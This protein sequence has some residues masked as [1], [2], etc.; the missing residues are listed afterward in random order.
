[1]MKKIQILFRYIRYAFGLL[2]LNI[3]T[4]LVFEVLYKMTMGII[5]KP[6]LSG[7]LRLALKIQGLSF[8]SD[9][10]IGTFLSAPVSWIFLLLI[11]VLVALFT[12]FDISCIILC[13]HASYRK[14]KIPLIALVVKG[15][16]SAGRLIRWKNWL[17]ILYLL[18]IIPVTHAVLLS[19]YITKFT[20]PDFIMEYI[21]GHKLLA[22]VYVGFWIYIGLRSFHWIY[23]LHYYT[24]ENCNFKVARKKSWMLG[25]DHYWK[26]IL[27]ILLINGSLTAIYYGVIFLGAY[28]VSAVNQVL[29]SK[30]L[31]S[32]L[33]LSGISL[34]LDVSGALYY[35]FC[36]PIVFLGIS[37]MFYYY[38]AV[39]GEPIA[40]GLDALDDAYRVSKTAWAQKLYQYRKRIIAI[41]LIVVA[42]VNFG[43]NFAEKK[44]FLNFGLHQEVQVTA[45]RGYSA[46][47]PEN[48]IPA[49][50][51]AIAI[52]A[53][54]IELDVQQT[55]DGEIVVMHDSSLKRTTGVNKSI[56][57]VNYDE[58][59]DLDNG[60]WYDRKF[61]EVRIPT[62]EEVL[63]VTQGCIRLN[64]EIKPN[65]HENEI[66]ARVA[67]LLRK[68]HMVH[69]CLISSKKYECLEKIKEADPDIQTAYIMSVS[70]GNFSGLDAADGYSVEATTT[71]ASFVKRA[72]RSG[73]KV[74]VWTVNSEDRL[75]TV[76]DLGVD[77]V[78]TD[79][80]VKAEKLIYEKN[81]VSLWDRYT[82]R[83]L[84]INR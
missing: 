59:K 28:L 80:P 7:L 4:L 41:C 3:G 2:K 36:L 12:L 27:K 50:K 67:Q 71:D 53:D 46:K 14:Q 13:I 56:W 30:D 17:M 11:V 58:I 79:D 38:K 64:I 81:H 42:A 77:N 16:R 34:L 61:Q 54:W 20:V 83:L 44:G 78:I 82:D 69:T 18:I 52:G 48:T 19:G 6:L 70:Y 66:E 62:L 15:F 76:I 24:L 23:S 57:Q 84:K 35:C 33:T 5:F 51:G 31:F 25:K 45:H 68:Y 32:S 1:M 60:S 75:E 55:K 10:T 73:K 39:S 40:P 37:L 9:E 8:L 49:F 22:V 72:H 74:Y 29:A 65:G 26:D 63:K 43:Y 21:F 47:Y